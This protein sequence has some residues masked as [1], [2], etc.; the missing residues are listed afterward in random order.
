M[1]FYSAYIY[2][3]YFIA[4]FRWE[5]GFLMGVCL[6][7]QWEWK[8][9]G[10]ISVNMVVSNISNKIYFLFNIYLCLTPSDLFLTSDF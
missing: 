8:Y 6:G 3:T 9:L 4:K 10:H 7:L 1:M 2:G 5:S